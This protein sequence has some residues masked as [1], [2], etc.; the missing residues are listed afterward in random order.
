MAIRKASWGEQRGGRE[1]HMASG[2]CTRSVKRNEP[3]GVVRGMLEE[4]LEERTM[5][6]L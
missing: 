3:G 5:R 2:R 1:H 6:R 4:G